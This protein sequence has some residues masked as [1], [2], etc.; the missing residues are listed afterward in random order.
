M[1]KIVWVATAGIALYV[2][3]SLL[4]LASGSARNEPVV[5]PRQISRCTFDWN[6]HESERNPE[7]RRTEAWL[8]QVTCQARHVW[9]RL[10]D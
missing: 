3:M 2:A 8:R 5:Q 9:R 10:W 7:Y 6:A 1:P 4:Y